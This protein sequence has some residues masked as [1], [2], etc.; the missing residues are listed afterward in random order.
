MILPDVNV[1]VHA[2]RSDSSNHD[3][4]RAWLDGVVNGD[5]RYGMAPQILSGVVRITTHP[6]VFAEPSTLDEVFRFCDILLAQSHC[7]VIQPGERHWEIFTRLCTEADARGNLVPD[8]WF[9]ALAIESGCE[10]ITFDRDFARFP[11]L[12]WRVPA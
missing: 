5:A 8:S 11:G 12:R 2:F 6:K 4:C 10:W 7:L 9:A 3:T 1:L